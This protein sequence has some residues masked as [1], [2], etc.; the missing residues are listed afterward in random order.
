MSLDTCA[1]IVERGDPDRFLATLA[2]PVEA[3]A[4]LLPLYAFNVE[5]ARLPW[6]SPETMICEM[7]LQWWR[8]LLQQIAEGAAPDTHEIAAPLAEV[9]HKHDLPVEPLDRL[10]A[11]R[12]WDIYRDPFEDEAALHAYLDATAGGLTW[13]AACAL[14]TRRS[15]EPAI[16]DAGWA[17][18]LASYLRAVPELAARGRR[19]LVDDRPEAIAELAQA[20]LARLAS[21]RRASIP[22]EAT[23]ALRAGWRAKAILKRAAED[24]ARVARGALEESEFARRAGLLRRALLGTW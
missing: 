15:G 13:V 23:P 21:A 18:G 12:R 4:V 11:A 10:V 5:V 20:G 1:A 24:P 9:I 7:R 16:R 14:G 3:R 8:D 19:P 6:V 22:G 17:A 2:A